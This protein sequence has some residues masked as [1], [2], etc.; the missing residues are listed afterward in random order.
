MNLIERQN[1]QIRELKARL[2]KLDDRIYDINGD[3][4]TDLIA[5]SE[6]EGLF[7]YDVSLKPFKKWKKSKTSMNQQAT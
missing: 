1:E 5:L 2:N 7:W 6:H 4:I 3:S